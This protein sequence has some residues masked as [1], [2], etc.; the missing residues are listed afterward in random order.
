MQVI[1]AVCED[2][3][4]IL[5]QDQ[6]PKG[7]VN[8]IVTV[9]TPTGDDQDEAE[10]L[11]DVNAGR[12]FVRKWSGVLQGHNIEGWRERRARDRLEKHS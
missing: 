3:R 10:P 4:I 12:E 6:A 9:L 7:R 2:G 1:E 11:H 5:P 8:V